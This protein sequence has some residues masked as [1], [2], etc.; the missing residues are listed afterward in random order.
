MAIHL[1][2]RTFRFEQLLNTSVH[3]NVCVETAE[4]HVPLLPD[5]YISETIYLSE[6]LKYCLSNTKEKAM[7]V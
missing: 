4:W 1:M 5:T 6:Q 7:E 2:S 3:N